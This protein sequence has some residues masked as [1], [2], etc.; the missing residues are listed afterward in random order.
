MLWETAQTG[1]ARAPEDPPPIGIP[2]AL[3]QEKS[4]AK[5]GRQGSICVADSGRFESRQP[6]LVIKGRHLRIMEEL[7][8][9]RVK[10]GFNLNRRQRVVFDAGTSSL[11]WMIRSVAA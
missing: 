2:S 6:L 11:P 10:T 4:V 9:V 1:R 7:L 5:S 3:L 8:D